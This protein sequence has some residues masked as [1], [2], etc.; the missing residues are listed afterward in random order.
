MGNGAWS[1]DSYTARAAAKQASG[2]STF[3]YSDT[4][5]RTRPPS[6][7]MV[8]E[9]LDPKLTNKNGANAGKNIRE[10]LDT[11]EH[12]ESLPIAVFFDVTGSMHEI[13]IKL[14]QKLPALHGML[15]RKG[16]VEHPQILFGAIGDAHTDRVPLQVGQFESDNRMDEQL[17]SIVLERGGGGQVHESYELALYYMARHVDLDSVK[18]RGKKGYLFLMGDEMPYPTINRR[19]VKELIGDDLAEDVTTAQIVAELKEK[20]EVFFLFVAEG[21]YSAEQ[22]LPA[23]RKL[24]GERALVLDDAGGVC[25]TI[26]LTLGVLEGMSELDAAIADLDEESSDKAAVAAAGKAVAGVG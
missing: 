18:R 15:M 2:K 25:E 23:W 3:D 20:W 8:H 21:S 11:D 13:P 4:I 10:A 12:P 17:E 7:W 1:T 19:Q 14:Q 22:I 6:S 5:T 16:Y 26:A 9:D 24:L